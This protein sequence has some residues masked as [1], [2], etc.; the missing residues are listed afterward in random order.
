MK[1]RAAVCREYNKPIGIEEVDLAPP[2]ANEV[3]VKTAFTGF[4]H[5][6]LSAADGSLGFPI[7]LVIGHEASGV[8]VDTGPGVSSVE[9]GD[10]VVATWMIACG[11]CPEC[12][13]GQ[14][15]ICRISHGI[16]TKGGLWDGTSRLTDANGDRLNHMTF[17]A[18]FAEY[19]VIP[20]QGTIKIADDF[21]LDQACFIGC[22]VPT[23]YGAVYN[24]AKV[25]PGHSVAVWG[26][27][28]VGLNVVRG[29]K[30]RGAFPIIGV[31]LEGSKEAIAR[32]CGVSHFINS[33]EEDPVQAVQILTGGEKLGDGTIEGGGADF[34]FEVIGDPGAIEQ[35]YWALGFGG[36]LIQVGI[37]GM[38]S[39][40]PL[41]LTLTPPH[42]RNILG[43]LYGNVRTHHELPAIVAQIARGEYMDLNKLISHKFKIDDINEVYKAMA[44]RKII[45][46]WL[47]EWD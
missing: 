7:P 16:H 36:K 44:E 39:R 3:L 23:G 37:P 35:A 42:N 40:T 33:S 41:P 43:T 9:K 29:A 30:L 19:M 27:G 13:S 31:D 10:R 34:C 4:C 32:E 26:L 1:M 5:S 12:T 6:D 46:R 18:G 25:T 24:V 11:Q 47:C 22:C 2:K 14:G 20:E 45:G 28:G 21:P 38:A 8:V 17:V 15:H